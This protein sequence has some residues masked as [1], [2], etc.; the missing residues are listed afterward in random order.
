MRELIEYKIR[1]I[2]RQIQYAKCGSEASPRPIY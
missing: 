2:F 1:N